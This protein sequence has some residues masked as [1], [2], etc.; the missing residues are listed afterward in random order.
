MF[1]QIKSALGGNPTLAL[2]DFRVDK[3]LHMPAIDANQVIVVRTLVK[4]KYRSTRLKMASRKQSSLFKLGQYPVHRRQAHV[5]AIGAEQP[6][7]ILRA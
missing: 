1:L 7:Y 2:F 6:V 5:Q 3:F 4:L